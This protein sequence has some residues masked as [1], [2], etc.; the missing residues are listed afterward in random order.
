MTKEN[1]Q[2]LVFGVVPE[3]HA[4]KCP[5]SSFIPKKKQKESTVQRQTYPPPHFNSDLTFVV[6]EW[7]I[8]CGI[9]SLLLTLA[10]PET[11][12]PPSSDLLNPQCKH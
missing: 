4:M 5:L 7:K 6:I 2:G 10:S 9:H 11:N 1:A 12:M 8:I 3:S